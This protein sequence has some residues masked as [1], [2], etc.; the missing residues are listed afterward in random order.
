[1]IT[2]GKY[3]FEG[4]WRIDDVD[5]LDRACVYAILCEKTNNRYDVIYIGESGQIG[6]RLSTHHR[7]DCW[8]NKC[9]SSLYVAVYWTP[10]D[11]YSSEDRRKIEGE[12][13]D[14]YKPSCNY[15]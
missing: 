3:Q 9:Q 15:Q 6:T 13:R 4:P 8:E 1:M 10:S 14:E 7:K 11:R 12:L 2:I 5:L